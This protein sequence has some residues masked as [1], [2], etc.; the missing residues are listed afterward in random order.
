MN[1]PGSD[2][3]LLL[4]QL[5]PLP[6]PPAIGELHVEVDERIDVEDLGGDGF[7]DLFHDRHF[8]SLVKLIHGVRVDVPSGAV[9]IAGECRVNESTA[10]WKDRLPARC[11]GSRQKVTVGEVPSLR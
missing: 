5:P 8:V 11:Q 10:R 2:F 7:L 6:S 3:D 1:S 4:P 9:N